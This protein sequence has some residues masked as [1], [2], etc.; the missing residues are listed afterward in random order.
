MK[1]RSTSTIDALN[2]VGPVTCDVLIA[3]AREERAVGKNEAMSDEKAANWGAAAISTSY[4]RV[5]LR[6]PA[7]PGL[8]R[9]FLKK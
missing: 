4:E 2:E 5:Y 8:S 3:V 1:P 7:T 6:F 9:V